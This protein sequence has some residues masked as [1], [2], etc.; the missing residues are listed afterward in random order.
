MIYRMPLSSTIAAFRKG[1]ETCLD[2]GVGTDLHSEPLKKWRKAI[3]K[4]VTSSELRFVAGRTQVSHKNGKEVS[5]HAKV[6]RFDECW[7]KV[8]DFYSPEGLRD[9]IRR[10]NWRTTEALI[11]Q[12]RSSV[13][14]VPFVGAGLSVDFGV[15]SWPQFLTEAAEFHDA[16]EKVLAEIKASRLI[17]AATLLATDPDRFQAMVAAAF[18]AGVNPQKTLSFAVGRLPLL[19]AGPVITT[20]FDSV[21][22]TAF[23]RAGAQFDRVITGTEPDNVIRAMHRNEHALIKIHGDAADRTARVF[24]GLEYDA[25]YKGISRLARVMFTNRP[26]LFLGCSLD[27]DRTLDVLEAIHQ[28]IPGL[29]HYAVLAGYYSVSRT[30]VRRDEL[31]RGFVAKFWEEVTHASTSRLRLSVNLG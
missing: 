30:R 5:T 20:N 26:L 14:I 19:A 4:E 17:Q 7:Q 22:E 28:E 31:A 23:L 15:P 9:V 2:L 8:D 1:S 13:G 25:Q 6:I 29:A 12:L 18:G 3:S 11:A 16:P 10:E 21:L 27:K 24:T